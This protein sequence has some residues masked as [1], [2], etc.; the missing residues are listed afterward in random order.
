MTISVSSLGFFI[1]TRFL[2]LQSFLDVM[3]MIMMSDSHPVTVPKFI[4]KS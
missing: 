3:T 2:D 1:L 4:N